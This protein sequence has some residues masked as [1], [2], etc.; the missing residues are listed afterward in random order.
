MN[1]KDS[2]ITIDF[3][4]NGV[5]MVAIFADIIKGLKHNEDVFLVKIFKK[6]NLFSRLRSKNGIMANRDRV[7]KCIFLK[8]ETPNVQL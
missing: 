4:F 6:S 3:Y 7:D 5:K 2:T 1:I 8:R